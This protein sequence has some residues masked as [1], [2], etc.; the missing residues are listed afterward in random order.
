[1]SK[2]YSLPGPVSIFK[3]G[4]WIPGPMFNPKTETECGGR[5]NLRSAFFQMSHLPGQN[6]FQLSRDLKASKKWFTK[7]IATENSLQFWLGEKIT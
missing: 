7:K 4:D 3:V 6:D 5:I 2:I 1:M